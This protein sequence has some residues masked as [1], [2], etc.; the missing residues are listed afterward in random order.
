MT[1]KDLALPRSLTQRTVI[2]TLLI[3]GMA[4]VF[5]LLVKYIDNAGHIG[6]LLAGIGTGF[7]LR[8][9]LPPR[10]EEARRKKY[11]GVTGIGVLILIVGITGGN[12]FL[13]KVVPVLGA[14]D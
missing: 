3:S 9:P 2:L 12:V 8:R 11:L 1:N 5:G 4:L 7:I 14:R 10:D 6:G 13:K